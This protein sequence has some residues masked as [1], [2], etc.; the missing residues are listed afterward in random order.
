[1]K[2]SLENP[3]SLR[4]FSTS[5]RLLGCRNQKAPCLNL[6]HL[7]HASSF[8]TFPPLLSPCSSIRLSGFSA[9]LTTLSRNFVNVHAC[10]II[11][12]SLPSF[13]LGS[14][15][16]LNLPPSSLLWLSYPPIAE[17]RDRAILARESHDVLVVPRFE[18]SRASRENDR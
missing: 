17:S 5:M 3:A 15:R 9:P 1:M 6:G 8:S 7:F 18:L 10:P 4:V 16:F 14:L 12:L 11:R 2:G 13:F